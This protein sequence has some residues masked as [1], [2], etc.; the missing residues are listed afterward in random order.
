MTRALIIGRRRLG[1]GIPQAVHETGQRLE[2][3]GWTIESAV[4][5]RKKQL[6]KRTRRAVKAEVDVVVAV[7]GDGAVSQVVQAL[8]G[9]QVDLGIVPMG[10]GNLLAGN[11]GIPRVREQAIDVVLAGGRRRIDLGQVTIARRRKVFAVACGIG[12]DAVVMKSTGK[13]GKRRWGKLA[14]VASAI[15]NRGRVRNVSHEIAIDGVRSTTEATQVFIANFGGMGLPIEPRLGIHPDDGALDV[16][17]VRASGPLPGLLAGW[18]ALRQR[19]LGESS[20]GHI[21]RARAREVKIETHPPRLV[22]IDGSVVG[23]TPIKASIRPAALT[24]IV[25]AK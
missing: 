22:E 24:V 20:A 16:I 12:F 8:A 21:F 7:G 17:V 1:R 4:V 14:Y 6:R 3:A 19:H 2:A 23:V 18:E 9:T 5:D 25:P 11:L 10:A 15:K 13:R